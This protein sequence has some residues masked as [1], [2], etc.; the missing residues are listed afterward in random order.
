MELLAPEQDWWKR[1]TIPDETLWA[2]R[3]L[4]TLD[5]RI[6]GRRTEILTSGWPFQSQFPTV[7]PIDERDTLATIVEHVTRGEWNWKVA[8]EAA[9]DYHIGRGE[10]A[11]AAKEYEVIINQLPRY[12]LHSYLMLARLYLNM[13]RPESARALLLASLAIEPTI[14]AY[15]A[16]GDMAL[17]SNHPAEAA[18]YYEKMFSFPQSSS[19]KTENGYLLGLAYAESGQTQRAIAQIVRVLDINPDFRPAIEL[20]TRLHSSQQSANGSSP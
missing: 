15:R 13:H 8:H 17:Q 3:S 18:P 20:L 2:D 16:L 12:D 7:A 6:A 9:A 4:T 14:L 10:I 19:E 5:E 11:D 1:D